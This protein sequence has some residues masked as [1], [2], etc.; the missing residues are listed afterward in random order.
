MSSNSSKGYKTRGKNLFHG[1]YPSLPK[2]RKYSK[3]SKVIDGESEIQ[4]RHNV[5]WDL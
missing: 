2:C 5:R 1:S 4:M 3:G